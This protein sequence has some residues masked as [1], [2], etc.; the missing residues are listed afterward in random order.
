MDRKKVRC[1]GVALAVVIAIVGAVRLLHNDVQVSRLLFA[2]A[3]G[4]LLMALVLPSLLRPVYRVSLIVGRALGW[5]N[6]QV[7]LTLTY[8]LLV[9]PIGLALR[10]FGHDP[11]ERRLQPTRPSYWQTRA[12][13][14]E[15]ETHWLRQF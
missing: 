12:L 2:T 14:P 5:F 6:S 15:G 11:L 13:P 8:Y 9:T 10:L 4:V 7:L 1:F 3:G